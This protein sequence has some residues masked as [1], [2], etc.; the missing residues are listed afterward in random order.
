MDELN[1]AVYEYAD[2]LPLLY[3]HV[4]DIKTV[5]PVALDPENHVFEIVVK[6][7]SSQATYRFV[8]IE[9][10]SRRLWIQRIEEKMS[11]TFETN[12][13]SSHMHSSNRST[14]DNS[15]RPAVDSTKD[16]G[17][18][19]SAS[20]L[21][22]SDMTMR[23][24]ASR[25]STSPAAVHLIGSADKSS[26]DDRDVNAVGHEQ[27]KVPMSDCVDALL[28]PADQHR[29]T[30]VRSMLMQTQMVAY[31]HSSTE[32][33]GFEGLFTDEGCDARSVAE[34]LFFNPSISRYLWRGDSV[35]ATMQTVMMKEAVGD[36]A[37]AVEVV[38]PEGGGEPG[39]K[40]FRGKK[41][42]TT[43]GKQAC[44]DYDLIF[45]TASPEKSRV[46]SKDVVGH[47]DDPHGIPGM[48]TLRRNRA[49]PT[50]PK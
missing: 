31:L 20:V 19:N 42:A 44:T 17:R 16:S 21:S 5:V 46:P 8:A 36:A 18:S 30:E 7:Q 11:S 35:L 40:G 43:S 1:F 49:L 50:E 38:G 15:N 28:D 24:L 10:Q 25:F 26:I 4:R 9:P 34:A 48:R 41:R 39:D 6:Q 14:P 12:N 22:S 13:K 29:L 32:T 37:A 27:T 47:P 2:E 45:K 3:I 23:K 33:Q